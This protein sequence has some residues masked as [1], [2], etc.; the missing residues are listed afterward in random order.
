MA[1]LNEHWM[2][3]RYRGDGDL[4]FGHP[5]L[6]TPID[7][8]KLT[9]YVKRAFGRA[10]IEKPFRP[11]HGLRHTSLTFDA[12]ANGKEHTQTRAGHAQASMTEKYVH[13]AALIEGAADTVFP[14][15]AAR[16]ERLVFSGL[17]GS[18]TK[19]GT[20]STP[21][22]SVSESEPPAMQGVR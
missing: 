16:S 13:M 14:E 6:G 4:V 2:A 1:A 9:R 10:G 21:D 18:G 7:P 17:D 3:S 20:N 5:A 12:A 15:A 11:W 19:F 8:G 22:E